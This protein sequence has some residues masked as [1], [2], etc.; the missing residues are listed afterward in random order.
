MEPLRVT[1]SIPDCCGL[2]LRSEFGNIV[3]TGD[4]KIDED[5][6]DG[7]TFDRS[8]FEDVGKECV[9]LLMSDST[10]VLSPGRTISERV[11][12]QNLMN[13]VL[14]W[15]GKGRILATQFASNIHRLGAVKRAADAAGR[16]VAFVGMS[17][18][19]YLEAADKSGYAPFKP[20]E[21][22]Q[23]EHIDEVPP[24]ELLVITTGSQ[25]T[26]SG[27]LWPSSMRTIPPVALSLIRLAVSNQ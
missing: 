11:V 24:N 20:E 22:V 17:L 6:L 16:R 2:I 23:P 9:A 14:E 13:K 25:V 12:E 3:H 27:G 10:N 19:T 21:L 18:N 26:S 5:P 1:H 7:R 8:A 4:W 15:N